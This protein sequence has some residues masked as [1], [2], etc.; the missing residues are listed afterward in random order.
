MVSAIIQSIK[1][2]DRVISKKSERFIVI[3]MS[4]GFVTK[5]TFTSFLKRQTCNTHIDIIP[6][7]KELEQRMFF[8]TFPMKCCII[9]KK[10]LIFT[11]FNDRSKAHYIVFRTHGFF[12]KRT[13]HS[14][15]E[16]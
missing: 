4:N 13:T 11:I 3:G 6:F 12:T 8:Q 5:N 1:R 14:G 16:Y 7:L 9:C 10:Q 2:A 15:Y